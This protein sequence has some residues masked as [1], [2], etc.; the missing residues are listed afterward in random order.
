[1]LTLVLMRHA[2]TENGPFDRERRLTPDGERIATVRG[3]EIA[4]VAAPDR[5]SCSPALRARQT[6]ERVEPALG[7][8][9]FAVDEA[10]YMASTRDLLEVIRGCPDSYP[11]QMVVAHNPGLSDLVNGIGDGD[12]SLLGGLSPADVVVLRSDAQNWYDASNGRFELVT[13]LG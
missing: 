13:R 8:P 4:G 7:S 1:M 3:P 9:K 6:W 11:T 10:L 5:V 2:H 12:R